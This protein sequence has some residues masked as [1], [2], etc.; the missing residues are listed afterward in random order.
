MHAD[1]YSG[2]SGDPPVNTVT[3]RY[4]CCHA[5]WRTSQITHT[6]HWF[7]Q[8]VTD[9]FTQTLPPSLAGSVVPGAA[10]RRDGSLAQRRHVSRPAHPGSRNLRFPPCVSVSRPLRFVSLR[11]PPF[12]FRHRCDYYN[13]EADQGGCGFT[14]A[15]RASPPPST[16]N[17]PAT[18]YHLLPPSPPPRGP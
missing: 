12:T 5:G 6:Y 1:A 14:E 11:V 17:K 7:T 15:Q 10:L 4:C 9:S 2:T 13:R 18:S 8:S 16:S 3:P